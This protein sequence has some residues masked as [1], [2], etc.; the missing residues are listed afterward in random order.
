MGLLRNGYMLVSLN[1]PPVGGDQKAIPKAFHEIMKEHFRVHS[2]SDIAEQS[3]YKPLFKSFTVG[4]K[5]SDIRDPISD[6]KRFHCEHFLKVHKHKTIKQL[7]KFPTNEAPLKKKKLLQYIMQGAEDIIGLIGEKGMK[8]IYSSLLVSKPSGEKQS[9]HQDVNESHAP[10]R[11]VYA[12]IIS[13]NDDTN[14]DI[15]VGKVEMEINIPAGY[16]IV[17]DAKKLVHRG[18]SYDKWNARIYLKFS[19]RELD[20]TFSGEAEVT[21]AETC[22]G[23]GADVTTRL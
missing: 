4:T 6:D 11:T 16:A 2:S 13:L 12:M 18:V 23:C 10:A 15:R 19:K 21:P 9:Y 1:L 8:P 14:V 7:D 3:I 5:L 20:E 17:F 22:S